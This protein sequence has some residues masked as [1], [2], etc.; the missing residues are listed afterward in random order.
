MFGFRRRR[1]DPA[2]IPV[3]GRASVLL[4]ALDALEP[5]VDTPRRYHETDSGRI[6]DEVFKDIAAIVGKTD[7]RIHKCI[8]IIETA[9]DA[10]SAETQAPLAR[11]EAHY[12]RRGRPQWGRNH[13]VYKRMATW[14]NPS[15]QAARRKAYDEFYGYEP[16]LT[17][18]CHS[19][20]FAQIMGKWIV[21]ESSDDIPTFMFSQPDAYRKEIETLDGQVRVYRHFV[22]NTPA[23]W[24][25][26]RFLS[27]SIS[28]DTVRDPAG[29]KKAVHQIA[30]N[31]NG[32][33]YKVNDWDNK[34]I[35]GLLRHG[36][37]T[38]G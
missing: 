22:M 25:A 4:Q 21:S 7:W 8:S 32:P 28:G 16:L 30:S 27:S 1:R 18:Q 24:G 20:T 38:S 36:I 34:L 12:A 33:N 2:P 31:Y 14:K 19:E 9:N 17:V 37:R 6:P 13:P 23:L 3:S 5:P 10:I 26:M 11:Q 15:T 35:R 29:F